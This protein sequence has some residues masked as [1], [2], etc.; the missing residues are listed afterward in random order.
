MS[1]TLRAIVSGNQ[2]WFFL[3]ASTERTLVHCVN[4]MFGHGY[5]IKR[6]CGALCSNTH[7]NIKRLINVRKESR[8][9]ATSTQTQPLLTKGSWLDGK[10]NNRKQSLFKSSRTRLVHFTSLEEISF[11][12]AKGKW[13]RKHHASIR[14]GNPINHTCSVRNSILPSS[15]WFICSS[16]GSLFS[17]G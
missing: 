6:H 13:K 12:A 1:H 10:E 3:V 16:V 9:S 14:F 17:S 4:N 15:E 5:A 2:N 7:S 11:L 8:Q